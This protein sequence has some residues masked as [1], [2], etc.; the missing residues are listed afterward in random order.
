MDAISKPTLTSGILEM[1][2]DH[3]AVHLIRHVPGG[4]GDP[5]RCVQAAGREPG[6]GD[7]V[8]GSNVLLV[9]VELALAGHPDVVAVLVCWTLQLEKQDVR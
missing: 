7:E 8:D 5:V 9:S 2:R 1:H 4:V 3:W 6:V